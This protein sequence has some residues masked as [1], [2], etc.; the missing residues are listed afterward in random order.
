MEIDNYLMVGLSSGSAA[1]VLEFTAFLDLFLQV[2]DLVQ[3]VLQLQMQA[4][5]P[6]LARH[7]GLPRRLAA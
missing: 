1:V 7:G 6:L 5:H 2:H 3:Q 4:V